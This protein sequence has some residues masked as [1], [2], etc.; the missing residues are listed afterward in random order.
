MEERVLEDIIE[1]EEDEE[2]GNKDELSQGEIL[3]LIELDKKGGSPSKR[4]EPCCSSVVEVESGG[5]PKM[6][7]SSS[8]SSEDLVEVE[9]AGIEICID[10]LAQNEQEVD[11]FADIF[12]SQEKSNHDS[13]EEL[14]P[15]K[16]EKAGPSREI[17]VEHIKKEEEYESSPVVRSKVSSPEIT[18]SIV[19][20]SPDC[21]TIKEEADSTMEENNMDLSGDITEEESQQGSPSNWEVVNEKEEHT[22]E[23]TDEKE[24]KEEEEH[25][26]VKGDTA[27]ELGS[28]LI[29]LNNLLPDSSI[30][31]PQG[32]V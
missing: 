22:K 30:E 31:V 2:L 23:D 24:D 18:P 25:K 9:E 11:I 27:C 29:L 3:K 32:R 8:S 14:S 16:G 26:K 7:S 20:K 10:P 28:E 6:S 5:S 1:E 17:E 15:Q 12:I 13:W 4:S 21:G 19:V